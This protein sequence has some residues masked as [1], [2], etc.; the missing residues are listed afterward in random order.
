MCACLCVCVCDVVS[1][2]MSAPVS[3]RTTD[4]FMCIHQCDTHACTEGLIVCLCVC[5]CVRVRERESDYR[6]IHCAVLAGIQCVFAC[7]CACMR[8]PLWHKW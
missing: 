5:V 1:L 3:W 6:A 4:L 7:V 2:C 8:A